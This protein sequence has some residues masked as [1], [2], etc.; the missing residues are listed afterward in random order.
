MQVLGPQEDPWPLAQ[1]LAAIRGEIAIVAGRP[2][3]GASCRR[4]QHEA[5]LPVDRGEECKGAEA[6]GFEMPRARREAPGRPVPDRRGLWNTRAPL[7][8]EALGTTVQ[9]T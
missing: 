9:S 3:M 8:C 4:A 2:K 6:L 1:G 5:R 7:Q